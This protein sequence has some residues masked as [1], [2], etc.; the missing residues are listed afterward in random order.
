MLARPI[1]ITVDVPAIR[2]TIPFVVAPFPHIAMQPKQPQ[3]MI[4]DTSWD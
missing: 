3:R 1:S 4:L 2:T